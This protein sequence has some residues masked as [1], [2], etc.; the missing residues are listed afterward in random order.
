MQ[1]ASNAV[2]SYD[3]GCYIG[4]LPSNI[5]YNAGDIVLLSPAWR[6]QQILLNICGGIIMYL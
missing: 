6:A 5:R 1:D 3:V 4:N 2:T